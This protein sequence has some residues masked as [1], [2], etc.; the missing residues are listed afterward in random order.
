MKNEYVKPMTTVVKVESESMV[1]Q[2]TITS[3]N[4]G[5]VFDGTVTGSNT[6]ARVDGLD[7]D[8]FQAFQEFNDALNGLMNGN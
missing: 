1:A 6:N 7:Y 4:S 5:G 2:S 3:I 8:A